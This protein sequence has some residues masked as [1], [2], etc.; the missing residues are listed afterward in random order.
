VAH[1]S[2]VSNRSWSFGIA[3]AI[4]FGTASHDHAQQQV[5]LI[6]GGSVPQAELT[7]PQVNSIPG[8][9]ASRLE[10]ARVLAAAGNW[11]E[12]VDIYNELAA[13]NTD[14]V[15][16]LDDSRYVSLPTYC[17]LQLTRM[18]AEGL[19]TYR[20]RVDPLAERWS[21]D[22]IAARDEQQLHRVLDELFCSS[23]CDDAL[24]ALGEL[25]LERG[26]Y[27]A[28]R[29]YWEQISSLLRA[30][31]GKSLWQAFHGVDLKYN[32][33]EI[34][35]RWQARKNSP[36]WLAYPDSQMDLA[37]IRAR[38]ILASVRAGQLD[39]AALELDVFRRLHPNAAGPLGGQQGPH[40]AALEKLLESAR[41][42][43]PDP[44][45]PDWPTFAGAQSRSPNAMAVGPTIV[46]VWERPIPL[47]PPSF[48]RRLAQQQVLRRGF[49][50]VGKV[51]EVPAVS[52][53][54]SGRPLSCFPV[55]F[56]DV[57]LFSDATGIHAADLDTGKPAILSEGLIFRSTMPEI[58]GN[59]NPVRYGGTGIA[60]G[61][62]RL[63][64]NV[65]NHVAYG[66]V[67]P[68][69]TAHPERRPSISG[70]RIVGL[71]LNREGLLVLR[72]SPGEPAWSFDG[73]PVSD[74]RR[75]F[76]AMRR[77]GSAPNAYV[78]C[79]DTTTSQR[80]WRS[81][82]GSAD[83]PA[84]SLG[85]EITHNLLTLVG[86][87]L[88]FNT[89]I[90]LVA[91]LDV[92]SG[93][94]C[95]LAKYPRLTGK[96]F[97]PGN[98][99]PLHF[100]RDASPA[101]YHDGLVIVAPA[102]TP[103][104]L[105]FD[106]HTGKTVWTNNNLADGLQLLGV[107]SQKLVVSGNR[108]ALVDVHTGTTEWIWPESTTS[109]IRGMG[110]GVI[111]GNEIFWPTRTEIY[112]FDPIS[113]TR[114]RSPISLSLVSDCGANLAA[115]GGRLIVAGYDKLQCFGPPTTPK[116]QTN[117]PKQTDPSATGG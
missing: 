14:R 113:G 61:V 51:E 95:W 4:L 69:A 19:A 56:D 105:A 2:S 10:Q 63:T 74:G 86:D 88:Y 7:A 6:F 59:E 81:N 25:A 87:R 110:R 54:E 18:P 64:L 3:L 117:K 24:L 50:F 72:V 27:D 103:D 115:A 107:V 79:F 8:T 76:V 36:D 90:G 12:A 43:K 77:S 65:V 33:P 71:D 67:G 47:A 62:P 93:E 48:A 68:L 98:A 78:A 17:Q 29:R 21:R 97:A 22:G 41:E 52:A 31:D 16:A 85:D 57:V 116:R 89:N 82:I 92:A 20:R 37:D 38:L 112:A 91:A 40:I 53:R 39:R 35:R 45:S 101:V 100:D 30:P 66:R 5:R 108:L 114:T 44:P 49:D 109:G 111:A 42:W 28:A 1:H 58:E 96:P 80:L 9:T 75:L 106:A 46:P 15:V 83:T 23:W 55:V 11:N 70:D 13:D 102:D 84:G 99:M 94:I 60:H 73:T 34:E 104:I 26:D 32:W